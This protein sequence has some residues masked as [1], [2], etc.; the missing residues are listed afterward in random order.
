LPNLGVF[1]FAKKQP[2]L[3]RYIKYTSR[4][5]NYKHKI[6]THLPKQ[7]AWRLQHPFVFRRVSWMTIADVVTAKIPIHKKA[8][9]KNDKNRKKKSFIFVSYDILS[10]KIVFILYNLID[11]F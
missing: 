3:Q 6:N 9:H 1:A 11:K 10:S 7:L 4:N 5:K 8:A 2:N